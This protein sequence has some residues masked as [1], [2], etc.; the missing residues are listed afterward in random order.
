MDSMQLNTVKSHFNSPIA[1]QTR[2]WI[3]L[4]GSLFVISIATYEFLRLSFLVWNWSLFKSL[5]ASDMTRAMIAGLRFDGSAI[6]ILMLPNFFIGL[7]LPLLA[8]QRI[9]KLFWVWVIALLQIPLLVLNVIDIEFFNF[10]GRRFTLSSLFV[11]QEAQGKM[12][13]F[14]GTYLP[15]TIAGIVLISI[16]ILGIKKCAERLDLQVSSKPLHFTLH[17]FVLL[18]VVIFARGGFQQKP[19]DFVDSSLFNAPVLNNLVLNTSFSLLKSSDKDHLPQVQFFT[20]TEDYLP[21]L[22]GYKIS[23]DNY[24]KSAMEGH[25]LKTKQNVVVILLESFSLEY[26]GYPNHREGFTPFLDD[27]AKR[28]LFFGNAFANGRRS[29]EGVSS[30]VAGIPALMNE[31][32]IT[33]E[34][35]SNYFVGLGSILSEN[36]YQSSFFHGGHNGTMYFDRF[37]KS[38]GISEYYGANEYSGHSEDNDGSWGIYDGPFFQFFGK[39]LGHFPEPFFSMIFSLSSHHPY[40]IPEAFK[41]K[42][43]KGPLEI[44]ESIQYADESLKDFFKY[45]KSQPWY[46]NTLFVITADHTHKNMLP[47]YDNELGRFRVPILFYHPTFHWPYVDTN[48]PVQH[49]D[50]LPSIMDFLGFDNKFEVLLGESVFK[51]DPEKTVLLFIDDLYYQVSSSVVTVLEKRD[52]INHYSINDQ[53]L[54]TPLMLDYQKKVHL[55]KKLKASIQYFNQ[56]MWDNRLYFPNK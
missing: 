26:M 46:N 44:L 38:A 25:R 37:A 15:G 12:S 52:E 32:F 17:F 2:A 21:Y 39:K 30:I 41:E 31:A 28:S 4:Y 14:L 45:A 49:I 47:S 27:L 36:K 33:S 8:S 34:F 3:L 55:E 5:A 50:I 11:F 56:G 1:R 6:A 22:N 23:S 54:A 10:A 48:Q 9:V 40:K 24:K 16:F 29:I 19:L 53:R 7:L 18:L 13:G 51:S 42:Y 20:K 35:A 43:K